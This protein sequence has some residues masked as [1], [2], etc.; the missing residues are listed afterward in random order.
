MAVAGTRK[1]LLDL[2][3]LTVATLSLSVGRA[4]ASIAEEP[5]PRENSIAAAIDRSG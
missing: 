4:D 1:S 2:S 3:D 5:A